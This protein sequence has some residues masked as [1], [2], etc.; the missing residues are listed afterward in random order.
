MKKQTAELIKLRKD[1][2]NGLL[3]GTCALVAVVTKNK[4]YTANLG[5]S[6]GLVFS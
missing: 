1:K 2:K 3:C 4:I 6:K 5:D